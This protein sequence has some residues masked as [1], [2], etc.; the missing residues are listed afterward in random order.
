MSQHPAAEAAAKAIAEALDQ[1]WTT[2]TIDHQAQLALAGLAA[3]EA[4]RPYIRYEVLSRTSL[5]IAGNGVKD[6]EFKNWLRCMAAASRRQ[7]YGA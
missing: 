2:L 5:D 6:R 7:A 4:L 3:L 1:P